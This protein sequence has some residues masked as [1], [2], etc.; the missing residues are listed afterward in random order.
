MKCSFVK[1]FHSLKIVSVVKNKPH[2][3]RVCA[4][5]SRG[6][7]GRIVLSCF[8][9]RAVGV[10]GGLFLLQKGNNESLSS[11]NGVPLPLAY[12]RMWFPSAWVWTAQR[13]CVIVGCTESICSN[14]FVFIVFSSFL[15]PSFLSLLLFLAPVYSCACPLVSL[16]FFNPYVFCP[17]RTKQPTTR[18]FTFLFFSW[19]EHGEPFHWHC[20]WW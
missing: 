20:S 17:Y 19:E 11:K 1:V 10:H 12:R 3:C 7:P 8:P 4:A 9:V 2:L 15:P 14:I 13:S 16:F 5:G 6:S 18:C